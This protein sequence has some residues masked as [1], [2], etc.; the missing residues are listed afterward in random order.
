MAHGDSALASRSAS[1]WRA[2]SG[3]ALTVGVM[4]LVE[5]LRPTPLHFPGPGIALLIAVAWSTYVGGFV[6]GIAS[7]V[8]TIAYAAWFFLRPPAALEPGHLRRLVDVVIGAPVLAIMMGLLR[9]RAER[10]RR[11]AAESAVARQYGLLFEEAG[12]PMLLSDTSQ[13]YVFVNRRACEVTGYTREE[14]L[15]MRVGD[16]LPRH[17][18]ERLG[19]AAHRHHPR[20]ARELVRR[21]GGVLRVEVSAQRLADGSTLSIVHDVTAEQE[22]IARLQR[23][24]AQVREQLAQAEGEALTVL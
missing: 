7:C 1:S 12:E 18:V 15:R 19:D 17:P 23:E 10:A 13:R 20:I 4:L 8:L 9:S 16:L 24:L 22:S 2:I 6:P 11:E 21:D 3:P 14:L 5:A